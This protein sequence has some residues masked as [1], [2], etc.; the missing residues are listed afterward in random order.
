MNNPGFLW[1]SIDVENKGGRT[2]T[3]SVHERLME[4]CILH[5]KGK[6]IEPI[7]RNMLIGNCYEQI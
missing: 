5:E 7:E 4:H 6:T 3:V 2:N 1:I